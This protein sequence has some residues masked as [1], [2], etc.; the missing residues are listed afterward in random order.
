MGISFMMRIPGNGRPGDDLMCA[1][2]GCPATGRP[3]SGPRRSAGGKGHKEIFAANTSPR[4]MRAMFRRRWA[5]ETSY[6][7]IGMF[8]PKTTS[9]SYGL[10]KLR[11][12]PAVLL[13]NLWALVNCIRAR[14]GNSPAR[15]A[16]RHHGLS[17][18][19]GYR[20]GR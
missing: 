14:E 7:V 13:H 6:R 20:D 15:E 11:F 2:K 4:Q 1:T 19:H 18:P 17:A 3:L 5:I 16:G 12:Y 9:K 8:L 10:R